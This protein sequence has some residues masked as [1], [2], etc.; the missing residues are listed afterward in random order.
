MSETNTTS[1]KKSR[2][3]GRK[4]GSNNASTPISS[5]APT[6]IAQY[7]SIAKTHLLQTYLLF[8]C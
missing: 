2:W 5:A 6:P 7:Q 4:L 8:E 3:G 1:E